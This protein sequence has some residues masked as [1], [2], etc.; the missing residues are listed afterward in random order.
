MR[1]RRS[2]AIDEASP[3]SG[4]VRAHV[5]GAFYVMA[6]L[7]A[8]S[9]EAFPHGRLAFGMGLIAV[10]CFAVVTLI[11]Y[12]LF[13]PVSRLVA[14]LAASSNLVGLSLE[15]LELH[16]R[17]VN[18]ALIFHGLYCVLI[19]LLICRSGFLPRI[20]GALITIGGLA[21]LTDLSVPLTNHL[22]PYNVA[23]GFLGEGLPMIWLLMIG[24]NGQRWRERGLA[25]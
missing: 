25:A 19:G 13:K 16:L 3:A 9:G 18:V 14:L 1:L 6:V 24:V 5:A 23:V 22:V 11:L 8:I 2:S 20:L 12:D 21:W 4:R 10:A 7:T 17:G 15:A